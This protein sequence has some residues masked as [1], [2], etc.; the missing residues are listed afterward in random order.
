MSSVV[1]SC[2]WMGGRAVVPCCCPASRESV[3]PSWLA[4]KKIK[5]QNLSMVSARCFG[6]AP[7]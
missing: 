2:E 3:V 7:L 1:Y 6:F 4:Q 5:V